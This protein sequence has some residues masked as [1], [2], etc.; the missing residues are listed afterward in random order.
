MST[1][2]VASSG[3]SLCKSRL[4]ATGLASALLIWPYIGLAQTVGPFA[5][6]EGKW[7]GSGRVTGRDGASERITC[8]A[9]Y[10]IPPSG[11]ALSQSL[12]CASDSYR[13]E[14]QSDVVATDG[15]TVQ[16]KWLESTR[17]VDGDLNGQIANGDFEGTVEGPSF[18][19]GISIRTTSAKQAVVITPHNG[20]VARVDIVMTR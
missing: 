17:H 5:L 1:A 15:R 12:V 6:F 18:S 8:R 3:P 14:V 10:S 20:D 7:R 9:A 2:S 16:G 19:A 13:F 11:A 4:L